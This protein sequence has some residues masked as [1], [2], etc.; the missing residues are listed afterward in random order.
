VDSSNLIKVVAAFVAGIVITLGGALIYV[1]TNE[2]IHPQLVARTSPPVRDVSDTQSS[3]SVTGQD[4][5]DQATQT[6]AVSPDDQIPGLKPVPKFRPTKRA[7]VAKPDPEPTPQVAQDAAPAANEPPQQSQQ[8]QDSPAPQPESNPVPAASESAPAPQQ[9]TVTLP[10]GTNVVVR[11]AETLSP[12]HNYTGDAFRAIL[13]SPIIT[14]GFIIADKGSKVLGTITNAQQAGRVEGVSGLTLTLTEINTTDG[15]RV[16]VETSTWDK[17]GSKST[18]E[19][20][21]KIAGGA[22]LGAIIGAIAG[23]GKG[24]AIG[25]GAG[26]AAGAGTVLVTRGKTATLPIETQLTFRLANPVTITE[27]LNQQP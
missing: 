23:G 22:A 8:P 12:E 7:A 21:A 10:A 11:L 18:G 9:H 24:A 17:K 3:H 13:E 15:Q 4:A 6:P 2:M 20:T 27:K 26:G 19:D 16:K 5:S 14:D 25:A 1:R